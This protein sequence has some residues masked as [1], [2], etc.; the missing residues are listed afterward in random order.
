MA[1]FGLGNNITSEYPPN[2]VLARA[3][4]RRGEPWK[5]RPVIVAVEKKEEIIKKKLNQIDPAKT[6]SQK[7]SQSTAVA[8][9]HVNPPP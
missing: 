6:P 7:P 9:I 5:L 1:K 2:V 4:E 3:K 8:K